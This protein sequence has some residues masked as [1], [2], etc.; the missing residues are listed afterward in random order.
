L[1]AV[2][3]YIAVQTSF[4][5]KC[6]THRGNI[7]VSSADYLLAGFIVLEG[8]LISSPA[9]DPPQEVATLLPSLLD[10]IALRVKVGPKKA[11]TSFCSRLRTTKI[12]Y[13]DV[14]EPEIL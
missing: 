6:G 12:G 5:E 9:S 13:A 3:F 2:C 14:S 4:L 10:R 7:T 11:I 8:R 1:T